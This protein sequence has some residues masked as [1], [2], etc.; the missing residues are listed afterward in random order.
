MPETLVRFLSWEDPLEKGEAIPSSIVAWRTP[1]RCVSLSDRTLSSAAAFWK[2]CALLP[3][4][5]R[6]PCHLQGRVKIG[7]LLILKHGALRNSPLSSCFGKRVCEPREA[8]GWIGQVLWDKTSHFW[9]DKRDS[10]AST[11]RKKK[12][13]AGHWGKSA[14]GPLLSHCLTQQGCPH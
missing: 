6:P 13:P 14:Q 7:S 11:K 1:W 5:P 2:G 8:R 10:W 12:R 4:S 3:L 9:G